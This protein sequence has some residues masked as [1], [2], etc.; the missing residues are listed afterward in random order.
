MTG[1]GPSAALPRVPLMLTPAWVPQSPKP[2]LR[3]RR[4]P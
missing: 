1:A 4:Q 2:G 3:I